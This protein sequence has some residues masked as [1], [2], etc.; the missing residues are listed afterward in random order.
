[1]KIQYCSDLHLEFSENAS[2]MKNNGLIPSGEVLLIAGDTFYLGQEF[3]EHPFFDFASDNYD[4]VYLIPGNHEYY[5]GFDAEICLEEDYRRKI[6]ENVILVNNGVEEYKGVK[7][8]FSTLWSRIENEIGP[9]LGGLIDFRLI[10]CGNKSL[11]VELYNR[12]FDVAWNFLNREVN[13]KRSIPTVV[14]THHMPSELCSLEKYKGSKLNEA[15][16]VDLTSFV[17]ESGID[18]WIY[19]HSHGNKE[20]F[21]IGNTKLITNQ[22]GYIGLNEHESFNRSKMFEVHPVFTDENK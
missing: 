7:F 21:S 9:I 6:R 8:V 16:Y 1:M 15:F 4:M 12:F 18:Y 10:K 20:D 3:E 13:K 17:E 2:W 5:G 11:S 22:L 14:M 19:G